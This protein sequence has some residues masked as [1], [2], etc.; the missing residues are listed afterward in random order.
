MWLAL[1][2]ALSSPP[3]E[4]S[5]VEASLVEPSFVDGVLE[6]AERWG[7]HLPVERL[8][9]EHRLAADDPRVAPILALAAVEAAYVGGEPE[10]VLALVEQIPAAAPAFS[11]AQLIAGRVHAAAGDPKSAG[12]AWSQAMK[13]DPSLDEA[14][15]EISSL[16]ADLLYFES[17]DHILQRIGPESPWF[18]QALAG[19]AESLSY[20]DRERDLRAGLGAAFATQSPQLSGRSFAPGLRFSTAFRYMDLCW[21]PEA[22]AELGRAR[23][24]LDGW[25]VLTDSL[26]AATDAAIWARVRD[27]DWGDRDLGAWMEMDTLLARTGALARALDEAGERPDDAAIYRA[28]AVALARVA[29]ARAQ[30]LLAEAREQSA[31]AERR[32]QAELSGPD[33]GPACALQQQRLHEG[34]EIDYASS[35]DGHMVRDT[36]DE[37]WS[38]ELD[39]LRF[40]GQSRCGRPQIPNFCTRF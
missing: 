34:P 22:E 33:R 28:E 35:F 21:Y 8:V 19:R 14:I 16:Y 27:R 20:F 12:R 5:L 10:R 4:P 11:R 18:A 37:F 15:W 31:E 2:L 39:S 26:S 24:R 13:T 6:D 1:L 29:L 36:R 32:Y 3:V 9:A 23:A 25:T 7:D 38:D 30:R 17:A 40:D